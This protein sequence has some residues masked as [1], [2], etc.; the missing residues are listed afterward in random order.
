LELR[1][2]ATKVPSPRTVDVIDIGHV[3]NDFGRSAGREALE[4]FAESVAFFAQDDTA[5]QSEQADAINDAF[6]DV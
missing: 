2:A 6:G 3:E 5:R 1:W 4:L